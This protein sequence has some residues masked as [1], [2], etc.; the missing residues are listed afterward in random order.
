MRTNIKVKC[1]N[2]GKEFFRLAGRPDSK[3]CG[4]RCAINYRYKENPNLGKE[5]TEKAHEVV[6][7]G[8]TSGDKHYKW[9]GGKRLSKGYV[10]IGNYNHGRREHIVVAEKMI[11][12]KLRKNEVVHHINENKQDNRPENLKVMDR[13]EHTILHNVKKYNNK[14]MAKTIAEI[15]KKRAD[16]KKTKK[17]SKTINTI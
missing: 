17:V 5:L 13:G 14:S 12:R 10:L 4:G 11:G 6:R 15:K 2:C 16:K 9:N 7:G 1:I 8:A 3:Y